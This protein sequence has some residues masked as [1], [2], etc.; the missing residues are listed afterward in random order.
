MMDALMI[1]IALGLFALAIAYA[2]AHL[3][4][5]EV[6]RMSHGL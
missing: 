3:I 4:R 6:R 5:R 2:Y 1:A